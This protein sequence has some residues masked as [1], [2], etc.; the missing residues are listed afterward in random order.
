M[1]GAGIASKIAS[2][3]GGR[4]AEEEAREQQRKEE[5]LRKAMWVSQEQEE[6]WGGRGF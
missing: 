5:A 1:T 6:A 2:L 3:I 4:R